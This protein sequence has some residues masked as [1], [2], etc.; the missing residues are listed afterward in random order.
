MKDPRK[1]FRGTSWV[2]N[3]GEDEFDIF[4]PIIYGK[5]M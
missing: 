4:G 5:I 2:T 1:G 3:N